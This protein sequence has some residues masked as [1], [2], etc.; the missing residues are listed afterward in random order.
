[1]RRVARTAATPAELPP[2]R[3]HVAEVAQVLGLTGADIGF[4]EARD[5]EGAV[6][7]EHR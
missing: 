6:L 3:G 2:A 1:L 5:L 4:E 7:V